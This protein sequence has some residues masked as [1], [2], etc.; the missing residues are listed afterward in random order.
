MDEQNSLIQ[1]SATEYRFTEEALSCWITVGDVSLHL[2]VRQ[3]AGQQELHV[4]AYRTGAEMS[5]P[6]DGFYGPI[7]L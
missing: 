6:L 2:Y 3:E 4:N 1:E 5:E 7:T